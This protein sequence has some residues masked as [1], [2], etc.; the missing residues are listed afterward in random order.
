MPARQ[1]SPR[2]AA[3]RVEKP[4]TPKT[5]QKKQKTQMKGR[6]QKRPPSHIPKMYR[7]LSGKDAFFLR[8]LH[9]MTTGS[10]TTILVEKVPRKGDDNIYQFTRK[11]TIEADGPVK[12][13][14]IIK[15]TPINRVHGQPTPPSSQSSRRSSSSVASPSPSLLVSSSASKTPAHDVPKSQNAR[16]DDRHDFSASQPPSL[17]PYRRRSND[18]V[19]IRLRSKAAERVI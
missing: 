9:E 15:R 17:V 3:G 10:Q 6:R 14:F 19:L 8:K 5:V 7:R 4:L 13:T 16:S 11:L 1:R 12:E 2:V 18:K